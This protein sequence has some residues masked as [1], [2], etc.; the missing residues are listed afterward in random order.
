MY[1]K[2]VFLEMNTYWVSVCMAASLSE[3]HTL[4]LRNLGWLLLLLLFLLLTVCQYD[5]NLYRVQS[6]LSLKFFA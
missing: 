6:N 2:L 1:I 4:F 3:K 5:E